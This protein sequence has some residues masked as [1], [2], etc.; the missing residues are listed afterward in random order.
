MSLETCPQFLWLTEDDFKLVGNF[1][2][3]LPPVRS[4]TDR[5]ALVDGLSRGAITIV[6]T[7]HA[8]HSD[9]EKARSLQDAPPGSP[10]VQTLYVSC[11][12]LAKRQG[13]VWRAARWV[14]AAPAALAGLQESKGT[15]APGFDADIVIVDPDR[16]TRV[17]PDAM[18]SRQRHGALE[19]LEFGFSVRATYLRG[20][21][22]AGEGRRAGHPSGRILRPFRR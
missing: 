5:Q 13:D 15:I 19:G 4:A 7:D 22:V 10:G 18:R 14:S 6:A 21:L 1:M 20:S 3:M 12:E 11:L 8:P 2:K 16:A 9:E 17:R